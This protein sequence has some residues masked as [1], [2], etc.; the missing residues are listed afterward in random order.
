M[1]HEDKYPYA[2]TQIDILEVM[3]QRPKIVAI[4]A[5]DTMADWEYAYITTQLAI[6]EKARPGQHHVAFAGET[7]DTVYSQ[8]GLS[9]TPTTTVEKICDDKA[10]ATLVIPGAAT[11]GKGHSALYQ[12]VAALLEQEKPVSAICGATYF[13]ARCGFLN[14][15]AHTSNSISFL[16]Q[17]PGY[18]GERFYLD[19]KV[20]TDTGITTASGLHPI[21]FTAEVLRQANVFPQPV[22]NAWQTLFET[23]SE[24]S[25][26]AY[27]RALKQWVATNS[28]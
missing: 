19:A 28:F 10:L 16:Q 20:V 21:A 1:N 18:T 13:L 8:G 26:L 3:E 17:A 5:T 6:A 2:Y 15:R 24:K 22:I 9:I 12:T 4:Y 14:S 25:N 11:Y 23:A 27:T 7:L